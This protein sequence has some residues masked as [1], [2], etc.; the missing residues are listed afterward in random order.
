MFPFCAQQQ[1]KAWS[2]QCL[3]TSSPI[4]KTF[5]IFQPFVCR[6][7][8]F[9]KTAWWSSTLT[10]KLFEII[11]VWPRNCQIHDLERDFEWNSSDTQIDKQHFSIFIFFFRMTSSD[12]SL[13]FIKASIKRSEVHSEATNREIS[14]VYAECIRSCSSTTGS[15][16]QSSLCPGKEMGNRSREY[17]ILDMIS[18]VH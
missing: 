13:E 5:A 6:R 7:R 8:V 15:A 11:T 16:V 4:E 2:F 9:L 14:T 18:R 12:K 1:T 3:D 10:W 17:F